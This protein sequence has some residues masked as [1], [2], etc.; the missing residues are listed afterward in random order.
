MSAKALAVGAVLVFAG[1]VF[2]AV[3]YVHHAW[4]LDSLMCWPAGETK[5]ERWRFDGDGCVMEFL[6]TNV[7]S[8]HMPAG[9]LVYVSPENGHYIARKVP[10]GE[11]KVGMCIAI[12]KVP[13]GGA[14]WFRDVLRAGRLSRPNPAAASRDAWR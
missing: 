1:F 8:K 10:P 5:K 7:E 11:E 4:T 2:V 12:R 3:R 9:T 13:P 14:D 6:A